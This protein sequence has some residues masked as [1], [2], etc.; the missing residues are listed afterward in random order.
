MQLQPFRAPA[1]GDD[2][3]HHCSTASTWWSRCRGPTPAS[4]LG[5]PGEPSLAV[6][7]RV[8]VARSRM[9]RRAEKPSLEPD[10]ADLLATKVQQGSLSARGLDKVTRVAHTVAALDGVDTVSFAHAS[11]AFSLRAGRAVIVA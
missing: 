10:A 4:C 8:A 5:Q 1:I 7:R 9:A 3:R 2:S 6:A 11:E